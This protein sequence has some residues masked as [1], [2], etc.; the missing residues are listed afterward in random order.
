MVT[1]VPRPR[2]V[3]PGRKALSVKNVAV[4]LPSRSARQSASAISAA[5]CGAR[6]PTGECHEHVDWA[7]PLLDALPHP[8]HRGVGA[9]GYGGYRAGAG[10]Q[11]LVDH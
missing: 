10:R 6:P 2:E 8:V 3:M 5:G 9:V 1:I 11:Q 4:R 7:E